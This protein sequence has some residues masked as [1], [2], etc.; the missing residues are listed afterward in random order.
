MLTEH[1]KAR[2]WRKAMGLTK[3]RLSELT[4]YSVSII[5]DMEAGHYRQNGNPIPDK[6]WQRY[7]MACAAITAGADFTWYRLNDIPVSE[8]DR[9]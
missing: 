6:T 5:A 8:L 7:K 9:C 1:E 4:G 2:L 3:V